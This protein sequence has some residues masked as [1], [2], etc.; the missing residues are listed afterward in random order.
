MAT[1][2]GKLT[3]ITVATRD[4]SP[5]CKNSSLERNA[6]THDT[7]GYAPTGDAQT[8]AGGL[9]NATFSCSGVYDNTVSVGP[10]LVLNGL[11]GTTMAI[12]RK[13]EG[14]GTGKPNDAFSGIL[15]KYVETNPHDDIVTWSADFQVTGVITSTTQP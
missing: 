10:R 3:Q 6:A 14:A 15:T 11:E 12:I 2:H 8:F 7:T 5:Y 13:V 9:R 1:A 4:I